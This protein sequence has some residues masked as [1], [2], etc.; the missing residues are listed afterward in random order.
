VHYYAAGYYYAA[1][2]QGLSDTMPSGSEAYAS[3]PARAT[4][5][6]TMKPVKHMPGEDVASSSN[7]YSGK[8]DYF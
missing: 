2:R 3:A 4:S 5:T 8:P 1:K 6:T 7:P